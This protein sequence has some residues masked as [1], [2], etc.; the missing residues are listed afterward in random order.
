MNIKTEVT[1]LSLSDVHGSVRAPV[2]A[3]KWRRFLAAFGPGYIIAVGYMDPGNWATDLAAGSS[4]GYALLAVVLLASVMAMVLQALAAW[5]GLATGRDLAQLTRAA[6]PPFWGAVMW[7]AA[8][9]AIIACDVAEVIGGAIALNLLFHIPLL[10]GAVLTIGD[11]FVVLML[12]RSGMR[13]LEAAVIGLCGVIAMAL[14]IEILMAHAALG[15]ILA[16]LTPHM[17]LLSNP[18]MLYIGVGIIGATVMPH[19]LYL[20]S[21]LVQTRHV[22]EGEKARRS[23]IFWA[24]VDSCAALV[25]AFLVNAA[26]LVMAGSVFH[27]HGETNVQ[28]L[29]RAFALLSP[30]LGNRAAAIIFAVALLGSGINATVTGTLAGQ[31]V[32]EGFLRMRMPVA[33]RRLLTRGL[34]VLPV[35]GVLVL[36]GPAAVNKLL[37]L[38][39]VIL[40]LQLPF[41]MLPLM[42]FVVRLKAL[43]PPVWLRGAGWLVTGLILVFNFALLWSTI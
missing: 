41:A 7:V 22:H 17:T 19:N 18:G 31:V 4:Y 38:S 16:G 29:G 34:A 30:I 5:L 43:R 12:L 8:Q 28:D 2:G 14:F 24:L 1:D 32:M 9:S 36:A 42:F 11:A 26:I 20:H 15:P 21:A 40:S 25:F 3:G 13:L 39:Q 35:V 27:A 37:V 6:M 10:L 23:A 33:A